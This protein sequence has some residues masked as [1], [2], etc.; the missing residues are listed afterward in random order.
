MSHGI[1]HGVVLAVFFWAAGAPL[2][3]EPQAPAVV[4]LVRHAE[5]GD[6]HAGDPALTEL[7]Q[8]RAEA[9]AVLLEHAG[10]TRLYATEYRRTRETLAPL[11]ARAGLELT[12][13]PGAALAEQVEQL[14]QLP[15]GSVAVVAGHSNTLPALVRGLGGRV[16][17][18]EPT[19][20]GEVLPS[21]AYD[22]LFV[23]VL[24]APSR[25]LELRY[26]P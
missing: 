10:V 16:S 25:V 23:V 20:H 12:V 22:R 8:R 15:L 9:L 11:A 13:V 21:T 3:A 7:G 4:F 26:G 17:G 19:E 5:A 14:K 24:S 6:T 1:R 18:T 2:V